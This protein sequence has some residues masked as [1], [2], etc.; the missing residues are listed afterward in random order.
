[1]DIK[2][3]S[4]PSPSIEY[5]Q[6]NESVNRRTIEQAIETLAIN[7]K[8]IEELESNVISN[9]IRKKHFLLMGAKHG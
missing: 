3:I 7:L 9:A 5:D 4:L 8:R 6:D 1:M 2:T